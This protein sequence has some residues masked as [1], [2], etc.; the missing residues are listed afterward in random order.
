M[1]SSTYKKGTPIH[2]F[3]CGPT[4]NRCNFFRNCIFFQF[5][6]LSLPRARF[7][8]FSTTISQ[9]DMTRSEVE[10]FISYHQSSTCNIYCVVYVDDIIVLFQAC[11]NEEFWQTRIFLKDRD[12][13]NQIMG[14]TY[15][16]IS[17]WWI[18]WKRRDK[19]QETRHL[20]GSPNVLLP[21][22]GSQGSLF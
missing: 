10:H 20:D 2:A 1:V 21:N 6:F 18:L 17:M 8:R 9:F 3:T 14:S 12:S 11:S 19:F 5:L 7:N 16:L 15:P 22:Y 13:N 4:A